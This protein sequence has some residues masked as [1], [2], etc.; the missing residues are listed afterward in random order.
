MIFGIGV[1][2]A[3]IPR[4]EKMLE[5]PYQLGRLF[6]ENELKYVFSRGVNALQ[7]LASNY[8]AKE[9]FFKALGTGLLLDEIKS[10][11]LLHE[12]AG[13]PYFRFHGEILSKMQ[14]KTAHISISHDGEYALCYAV[15]ESEGET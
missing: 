7:S 8:A 1:D 4:F 12:E 6:T 2:I 10:V 3:K 9:A 11:E 5:S 13:R 14:G 15:I